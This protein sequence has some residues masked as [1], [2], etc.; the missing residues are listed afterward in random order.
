MEIRRWF[1]LSVRIFYRTGLTY[2]SFLYF[3]YLNHRNV[4]RS[5]SEEQVPWDKSDIAWSKILSSRRSN[6]SE[7]VKYVNERSQRRFH[8]GDSQG[9]ESK[10]MIRNIV[11]FSSIPVD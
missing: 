7:K 4:L 11:T 5:E 8:E 3:Q 10:C 9:F 6:M 2:L 1:D